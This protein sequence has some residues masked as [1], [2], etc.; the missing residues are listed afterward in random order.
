MFPSAMSDPT[1]SIPVSGWAALARFAP[2]PPLRAL[3]RPVAFPFRPAPP[4]PYPSAVT[5]RQDAVLAEGRGQVWQ[6]ASLLH[7]PR[8]GERATI[9][10]GGFV[11]DSTEQVFLLRGLLQRQGAVYYFNYSRRGFSLDLMCAQ[12]DDLIEELRARRAQRP[13]VFGVSFGAGLLIE[14]MRR[15][16]AAVRGDDLAGTLLVSPVAC[17]AD[18]VDPAQRKPTTLVGRALQPYLDPNGRID[19][20]VIE[21]SRTIFTKM[22]EAGAQNK[23]T[24][25]SLMSA[26]ELQHL[27]ASVMASI[28]GIDA[29]GAAQ[30]VGALARLESP[31]AWVSAGNGPLSGAPALILYAE[32]EGAVITDNSPS[33]AVF[34]GDLAALFPQ[35]EC[36]VVT[37]GSSPVQHASLIFHCPQFLPHLDRFY[38]HLR[39]RRLRLAA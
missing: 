13:V 31:R 1:P 32:K 24:L 4:K 19:E 2:P 30:R 23:A 12:L 5:R 6:L 14:W 7:H 11:P 9:V 34:A 17:A 36:A 38:R 16:R 27:H 3:F 28:R 15:R 10:L 37:G 39:T 18:I 21:R 29:L 22:F 20:A 35:G 8:A 26:G 25:R 33:R